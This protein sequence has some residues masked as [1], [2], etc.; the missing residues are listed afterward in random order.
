MLS[1]LSCCIWYNI[2]SRPHEVIVILQHLGQ[3]CFWHMKSLLHCSIWYNIVSRSHEVIIIQLHLVQHCFK[4]IWS[5]CY[6]VAPDTTLMQGYMKSLLS[7]L[8]FLVH[9][10]KVTWSHCYTYTAE[11]V[12]TLFQVHMK[13]LLYCYIWYNIVSRPQ[14][15][16]IIEFSCYNIVS[17][18]HEIIVI[19][20]Y[21]VQHYFKAT[22][23]HCYTHI[24]YNIVSRPHEVI[25]ILISGTTLF[26]GH[27]KSL[28]YSYLVQHCFKAIWSHCYTLISGTTLFQGHM[29]SLL[30]SYIWYNIVSRPCEVIVILLYLVQHCFKAM[31]SHCYTLISGTTLFQGHMKSLLYSYIW[32]NTVS[33]PCESLLY[34][35]IWYNIV[36]GH[37]M[38]LL[39]SYIWFN[40]VS[41][42]CEVIVILLYLEQHCFKAMWSHCY[43][44]ISG[45]TLFQGHVKS[46]LYSYIWYNIVSRP[47]E[48]IVILLYLVQHCFKAMWSHCYT[49]IWY[50]T[51]SRPCEVIVILLYLVQHCFKATL[52]HYYTLISGTALFQGQVKSL[53][54]SYIWYNTVSRPH[55]VIVILLYVVQHCFK[56][57]WSHCYTL[58]SGITLFQGH[59]KSL[60]Y[61]YIW[62]NIVQGHV[63]S[64]LYFYIWYNIVQGHVMSLL[65]SYI[66]YNTVSRPHEV[67]VILLYLVQHCFKAMWSHCYTL[68]SGTTLF[69]GHV[70]SLLYSYIWYNIV[71]RPQVIVILLY[72]VQHCFKAMWSH[73][74]TLISGTTLFQGHVKSLLYSYIWYNIVSRPCEVIVILLYLVQHCSRPCEVIVILLYLVQHCSRPCDVIVILISGTTLFQGHMK[75]LLYSYLVQHCFKA[76][77]SHCYT[78]ISGTTLFQGHMKSLL[79]SYIWYNIVSR[80]CEVI[81]ILLYL[82]QH[83]FKAMW[84]HWY[85]LISGTTLFQGHMKSLYTLIYGITLFQGHMKSLLYSYIWYNTVSRPCE[86][87]VILLYLVQHCFKATWSHCY[88][89]IS[90]T[91]LFQG[92]VKSLLYSYL[93]QHCFKAMWSHCYTLISGTTLFQGHMKSLLYSYIWYN[94][95]SRPHEV[96]VILLYLVQHCFKAMWSHCYTH[97]WYNIVSRPWKVIVIL[98]SGTTLFQDHMKSLLY[99]YIWYN[100]VSRPCEVIVILL[101]LV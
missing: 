29:K 81:V 44:L 37:V 59:V 55:E 70:K 19:L 26:Q 27:M 83:C 36:Q 90:G 11:S 87:I 31:W 77:W 46:L 95:V 7:I 17:R 73:C 98:I 84:S 71:S 40:I 41:R 61:S 21:L 5:P 86:V 23:S 9:Y 97:I 8:L 2:I 79:Y 18:P 58:I 74:Y 10:F 80:P 68:I 92:H 60:L 15:V 30:Y 38:S 49:H 63:K 72:L 50:N 54:Y 28:L 93:V 13:S 52:S 67:I 82:V 42:P 1:L 6:T 66:W 35:Y 22:W 3:H 24:W 39:Y 76:M 48:V 47:H 45:T 64:L 4:V 101:Y 57:M 78:L 62:Y 51:V 34:S 33:R 12:T 65:Y 43:T 100:I 99:C 32:Y 14:E 69:Q 94:I 91:T 56:A 20:L 96:I 53:L 75:S 89:L 88:T 85:T 25:V 16:I